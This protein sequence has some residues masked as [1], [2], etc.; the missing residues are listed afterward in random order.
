MLVENTR[1][2]AHVM[3]ENCLKPNF[4]QSLRSREP[5]LCSKS[6]LDTSTAN[7]KASSKTP[8]KHLSD[9][10][11]EERLKN[12]SRAKHSLQQ[13]GNKLK[14]KVK[15]LVVQESQ[16]VNA[17]Q[18]EFLSNVMKEGEA[19]V[20][21]AGP[22]DS[23][24]RLLWEQQV[25][26]SKTKRSSGTWWHP[27]II[28]WCLSTFLKS[29]AAYRQLADSGFMYLPSQKTLKCYANFT[30]SLPGVNPDVLKIL[31]EEFNLP[32][33]QDY[34]KNV[35]LVWDE[36]NIRS[37]LVVTKSSGR[38]IGFTSLDDVGTELTRLSDMTYPEKEPELAAHILVFMVRG[39]IVGV[40]LP[41]IWHLCL[42]FNAAQLWGAVWCA[43]RTLEYLGLRVR[44]WVCDGATPNGKFFPVHE[45]TE[46]STRV[47]PTILKID[48]EREKI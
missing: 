36:M 13:K 14:E 26:R 29:P 24:Q 28:R 5:Y 11:K 15:Q 33:C 48:I 8:F 4:R 20:Q 46:V 19:E 3:C 21:M 10:Q 22:K 27:T 43:T 18:H 45:A 39:L 23:P 9:S 7:F 12:I 31:V 40:N 16:Q 37:R 6:H 35:S 42:T 32:D 44:A 47:S 34:K 38:V 1:P 2:Q 25:K 30:D 41:F 17:D